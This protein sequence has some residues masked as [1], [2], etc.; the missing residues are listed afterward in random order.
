MHS[1]V[2]KMRRNVEKSVTRMSDEIQHLDRDVTVR[3]K[4]VVTNEILKKSFKMTGRDMI[5]MCAS[6]YVERYLERCGKS[7][8][9]CG[10][11]L[12]KCKRAINENV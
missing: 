3:M 4:T 2:E 10:G 5:D 6:G 8:K 9:Q 11:S 1:D 7:A 12:E